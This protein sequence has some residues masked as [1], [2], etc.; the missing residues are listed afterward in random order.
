MVAQSRYRHPVKVMVDGLRN[1]TT[2]ITTPYTH[3]V[4]SSNPAWPN[5]GVVRRRVALGVVTLH[6]DSPEHDGPC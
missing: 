2:P 1:S 6:D 3:S 5:M 4:H